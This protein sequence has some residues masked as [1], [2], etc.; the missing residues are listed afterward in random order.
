MPS[1]IAWCAA[2]PYKFPMRKLLEDSFDELE[3][4]SYTYIAIYMSPKKKPGESESQAPLS[5]DELDDDAAGDEGEP[6][7]AAFTPARSRVCT[8]AGPAWAYYAHPA[9]CQPEGRTARLSWRRAE[10]PLGPHVAKPQRDPRACVSNAALIHNPR[11]PTTG[12]S[13]TPLDGVQRARSRSPHRIKAARKRRRNG[14]VCPRTAA[15]PAPPLPPPV[16][17]ARATRLRNSR[18][19]LLVGRRVDHRVDA[20][21]DFVLE[22]LHARV[23]LGDNLRRVPAQ[24]WQAWAQSR[25]RC[26]RGYIHAGPCA[27]VACCPVRM[28]HAGARAA[29]DA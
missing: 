18:T 26:R 8:R 4:K 29:R 24:M 13:S 17:V 10:G 12:T 22:A 11:A 9:G 3:G 5:Y 25:R 7:R 19:L 21:V 2:T 15:P 14:R 27:R 16:L 23:E 1:E 6:R 28:R 20:R